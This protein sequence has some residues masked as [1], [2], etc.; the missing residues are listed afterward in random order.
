MDNHDLCILISDLINR[1]K[2]GA[3][4][5][6]KQEWHA[7]MPNLI[8]DIICFTNTVHD[9]DCY[10]IFG[11]NNSSDIVGMTLQRRTQ[12]DI[13]DTLS[14]LTFASVAIPSITVETITIENTEID[15][16]I[17]KNIDQ[18]PVFLKKKYGKMLPGCIYARDEDRNT[19]DNGNASLAEI[20]HL[21]RKHFGL[22][23][24]H[25]SI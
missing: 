5:D 23:S 3:Y 19:P 11:V 22:R 15:V 6:F 7:E 4:W 10:I 1:G 24:R 8:K 14:Q 9:K 2:E 20:E 17:V 16:L 12:A 13:I 25:F 21:W 18:T